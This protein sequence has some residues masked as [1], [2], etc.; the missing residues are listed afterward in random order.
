MSEAERIAA[1]RKAFEAAIA[2]D[3]YDEAT[4]R[5]YADWLS[6]EGLDDEAAVQY[7]WGREK[8]QLKEQS[9]DWLRNYAERLVDDWDG[10]PRRKFTYEEDLAAATDYID[11]KGYNLL[12]LPFQTP[13]V[14]TDSAD[15]F[16]QH[17]ERVTGRKVAESHKGETFISCSC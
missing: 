6:D 5:I 9:E 10:H 12:R 17:F 13:D 11:S 7:S 4:R 1:E 14:V 2:A 3:R 15:E 8:E 16:W